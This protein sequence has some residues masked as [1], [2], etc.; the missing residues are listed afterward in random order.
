MITPCKATV[1]PRFIS[2][3]SGEIL[4]LEEEVCRIVE[5][6]RPGAIALLGAAGTGKTTALKHLASIIPP[7]TSVRF[8]DMPDTKQ[9]RSQSE[10]KIVIYTATKPHTVSH[11]A[12]FRLAP[13]ST[14][15]LIEYL[16]TLHKDACASV[17]ARLPPADR[18][19]LQGVPELWQIVLD[20][21]ACDPSLSNVHGALRQYMQNHWPQA[22]PLKQL[23]RQ[24][25]AQFTAPS[26]ISE[27]LLANVNTS[28]TD[29][30]RALLRHNSVQ[31]LLASEQI[32]ADLRSPLPWDY[33]GRQLPFA[34][35]DATSKLIGSDVQALANVTR[36]LDDLPIYHAMA[37]SL[38]CLVNPKWRLPETMHQ[39]MLAGA[40]LHGVDWRGARL[41]GAYL[42][43]I[44]LSAADLRAADLSNVIADEADFSAINLSASILDD[45][46][47]IA[48]NLKHADLS[49]VQAQ[50]CSLDSACLERAN[51]NDAMLERAWL[52]GADLT[53][54]TFR[55]ADLCKANLTSATL[56]NA[57]FHGANLQGAVLSGLRLH[58]A[59]F[60][61]ASFSGAVMVGCDLEYMEL[62]QADFSKAM[63]RDAL[64]TGSNMPGANFNGANLVGAGLADIQWE[65]ASLRYADLRNASFHLG[66]SRSGLVMSPI[67][68]EG[69]KTG[70]YTDDFDEQLYKAPEEIRKANLCGADLRGAKVDGTDFYLVD[71]RGAQYD[72]EQEIHFRRCGAILKTCC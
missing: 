64:L 67:A 34:L 52:V 51:F 50:R 1:K 23:R 5:R 56:K 33:L 47:A 53:D 72:E 41:A 40:Y 3:N 24:C 65:G 20:E 71:L 16:L 30:L 49:S 69:S 2:E 54:A 4:P 48:I 8:L 22:Q 28:L 46:K 45:F 10:T 32:A 42:A 44:D 12:I 43:K 55:H 70:F 36:L 6:R 62:P 25:I 31:V 58:E 7:T 21:L 68:C 14:D 13:W 60:C 9:L 26:G 38:L 35:I 27:S 18:I 11:L 19:L 37:A 59:N 66:S 17:M 63:L 61:E 29:K 15:E 39:P 57:D